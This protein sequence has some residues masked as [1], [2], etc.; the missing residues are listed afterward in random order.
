MLSIAY[1]GSKGRER[2]SASFATG[3]TWGSGSFCREATIE[4]RLVHTAQRAVLPRRGWT[5]PACAVLSSAKAITNATCRM[6]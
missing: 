1:A 5:K 4:G 6:I 3:K 2:G